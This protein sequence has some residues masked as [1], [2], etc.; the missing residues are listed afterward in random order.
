M[1]PFAFEHLVRELFTAMGYGTWRTQNSGDDGMDAVAVQRDPLGVTVIAVQ[2]KRTKNLAD[3][4]VVRALLGTLHGKKTTR[5][6]L[7]TTSWY[8]KL[9]WETAHRNDLTLADGRNLKALPLE[10]LGI[11][12]L[13][14]LPK[15]PTG[16]PQADLA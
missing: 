9:S 12:A 5:G 7:V 2:A 1:D 6:V 13:I 16:W 8:G 4:E 15:I 14:G 10:H 3:P 11:D